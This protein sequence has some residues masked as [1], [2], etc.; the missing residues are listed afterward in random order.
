[1]HSLHRGDY[2]TGKRLNMRKVIAYIA[3]QFRKD[4]I[5][6]RRTEP[7]KREYQI[8]V[9]V[10]DSSSMLDNHAKQLSFEALACIA[11][12]LTYLQVGDM[13]IARLVHDNWLGTVL[14]IAHNFRQICLLL[15][16]C[17]S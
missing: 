7:S 6:L 8:A 2:R 5:W 17:C 11:N 13:A 9:A 14:I 3:S 16:V 10:D 15:S 4:S 12:A 1:M